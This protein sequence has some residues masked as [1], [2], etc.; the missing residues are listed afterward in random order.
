MRVQCDKE[1]PCKNCKKLTHQLP[2]IVCW[3]FQDFLPVLFPDFIRSHFKRDQMTKFISENVDGFTVGGSEKTCTIELFSGHR[4]QSTLTLRASFFT[5]KS[6][7]VLQHWHLH[8]GVN[9]L[10]LESRGAVPLGIDLDNTAVREDVRR[11]ARDYVQALI[12]EPQ[13]AEQV[14]DSVRHTELPR[15]ILRAVQIYGQRSDVSTN[16]KSCVSD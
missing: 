5:A 4:F 16:C 2:Q 11:K 6:P 7:E 9:S 12:F 3:Q 1:R 10:E 8:A 14:T 13:Y 15:K